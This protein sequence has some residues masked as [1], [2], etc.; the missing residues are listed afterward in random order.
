M[1]L[2]KHPLSLLT[3]KICVR[4]ESAR[5]AT[6]V[7]APARHGAEIVAEAP[8]LRGPIY[9]DARQKQARVRR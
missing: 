7:S 2:F 4:L 5:R 6:W 3:L 1:R 8:P 9:E